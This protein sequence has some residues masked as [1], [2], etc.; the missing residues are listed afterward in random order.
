MLETFGFRVQV[1]KGGPIY[2]TMGFADYYGDGDGK[3][4]IL[5]LDIKDSYQKGVNDS[6]V[7]GYFWAGN[8]LD[9]EHSNKSDMIY[10]DANPGVPG[11]EQ[12]NST[13]AHEM[14][15]LMN[16]MASVAFRLDNKGNI[17]LMDIW[18]DEGLSSAAEWVYTGVHPDIRWKWF[19]DNGA[20]AQVKGLVDKGN[21]FFVWNNY[22]QNQYALLDDYATVYLFFQWLRLQS[23]TDI[24]GDIITSDYSDSRAV[25]EADSTD[26]SYKNNWGGL[27]RDW[28][29][30]NYINAPAGRYGYKNDPVLKIQAPVFLSSETSLELAP[31]E[32]VYSITN[33]AGST[34]SEGINI[35][36][37]GLNKTSPGLNI[38]DTYAGGALLTFNANS[39]NRGAAESGTTTG[40]AASVVPAMDMIPG[41][42]SARPPQ[43]ALKGPFPIGAGDMLRRGGHGESFSGKDFTG[44]LKGVSVHE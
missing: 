38:S 26:T 28:L 42:R 20:G 10:I 1:G 44:L 29:T 22:K 23:S 18:I 36:Y 7:A 11:S 31:G 6:Y 34:P 2:D 21:N 33:T 41:S 37:A 19:N 30:A 35:K 17:N 24:Y 32:G 4:C 9:M 13:L 40:V 15:H 3:L 16:F 14:Q 39:T 5:I 25:T 43:A 8:I 12:S 27:L